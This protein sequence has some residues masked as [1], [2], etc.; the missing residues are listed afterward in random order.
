[1]VRLQFGAQKDVKRW[2]QE[3]VIAVEQLAAREVVDTGWLVETTFVAYLA[4]IGILSQSRVQVL[5]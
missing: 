3:E 1:M 5:A 2:I 4:A